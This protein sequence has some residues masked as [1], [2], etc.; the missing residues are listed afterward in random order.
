MLNNNHSQTINVSTS[1]IVRFILIILMLVFL[2]LIRDILLIVIISII[3]AAAATGP[4]S[5]LQNKRVPRLLGVVFVYL[6]FLLLLASVIALVF[7]PLS[8]QVRQLSSSFP[9]FLDKINLNIREWRGG[10]QI[11]G[12]LQ[13]LLTQIGNKISE[14]TASVFS[15]IVS[16][17][18]G[19]FSAAVI[20]VVSFY[21]TVQEKGLKKF[22]IS[23]TPSDHQ[24]YISNLIERIEVKIGGW[25]RGQL[26]L[27]LIV[28]LLVYLGLVLL[29]VKYALTLAL[30]AGILEI[31]PY[32]GP[33]IAAVPAIILAFLQ[34]PVLGL[35]VFILY[36]VVQQLENY[37]ILPQVMRK[38]VGLNP[39][40]IIVAMLIGAKLAGILGI[41][42]SVPLTAAIT[43]F[44]KDFKE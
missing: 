5:W 28:G 31:V 25:L 11:E 1:T 9:G 38:T 19:I 23:L 13:S 3:I 12:N 10:Y 18:G 44:V 39:I 33:I 40:I 42:L 35:L 37:I 6:L 24:Q 32:L 36:I 4:V 17:F 30:I 8:E 16:L 41:I 21:L 20:L 27:M 14:S 34:A 26:L 43:E 22:F 29:G 15:T 7:P 2:Y